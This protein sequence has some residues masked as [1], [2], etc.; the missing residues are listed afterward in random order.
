MAPK[1]EHSVSHFASG[2]ICE[3]MK[4][5]IY[6]VVIVG[7]DHNAKTAVIA[8][9][10][11]LKGLSLSKVLAM[12]WT[13]VRETAMGGGSVA[14]SLL[15]LENEGSG[16]NS[17]AAS[18]G[19]AMPAPMAAPSPLPATFA[20]PAAAAA[21]KAT[22]VKAAVVEPKKPGLTPKAAAPAAAAAAPAA[23]AAAGGE[24][25]PKKPSDSD[26]SFDFLNDDQ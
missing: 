10:K 18:A 9:E 22:P 11:E 26:I 3:I 1:E 19:A 15:V 12:G 24:E 6:V 17:T 14:H 2:A 5:Y 4:N 21:P 8:G 13:P 16:V 23:A 25:K 7:E 20:A